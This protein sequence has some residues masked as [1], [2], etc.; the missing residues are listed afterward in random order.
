MK[1]AQVE[2]AGEKGFVIKMKKGEILQLNNVLAS[3]KIGQV[4]KEGAFALLETKLTL[5]PLVKSIEE[6]QA[7]AANEL[8]PEGLR[9]DG[10]KNAILEKEWNDKFIEFMNRYLDE[11]IP[12]QLSGLSRE[13]LYEL[14]R[15]NNIELAK[16]ELL[17]ILVV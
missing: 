9:V 13:D 4:S 3:L 8:K 15:D 17:N 7:S 11:S 10:V 5:S 2:V 1:K 6:A 12:V 14:A 16:A